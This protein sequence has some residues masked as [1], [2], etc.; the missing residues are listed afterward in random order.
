MEYCIFVLISFLYRKMAITWGSMLD[1]EVS[2]YMK[3][4]Q[5]L[6][7]TRSGAQARTRTQ[8]PLISCRIFLERLRRSRLSIC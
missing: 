1:V 5:K 4:R 3:M 7:R 8:V 6:A 2:A